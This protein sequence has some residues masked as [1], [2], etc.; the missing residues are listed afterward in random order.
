MNRL[1][2]LMGGLVILATVG[3][4]EYTTVPQYVSVEK[5]NQLDAGMDKAAVSKALG[6]LPYDAFHST[7]SGCD[8]TATNT[9][10]KSKRL[11]QTKRRTRDL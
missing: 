7:E 8:C 1:L 5:L 9:C 4:S 2:T 3:C 11:S 10:T 6:A